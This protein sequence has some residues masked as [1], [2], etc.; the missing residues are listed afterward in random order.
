MSFILSS[1]VSFGEDLRRRESPDNRQLPPK[2]G[3]RWNYY[4]E[5]YVFTTQF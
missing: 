4:K 5:L 2:G 3:L 1:G